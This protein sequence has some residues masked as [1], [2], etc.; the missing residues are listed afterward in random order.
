MTD[1]DI[2]LPTIDPV[3]VLEDRHAFVSGQ[4]RDAQGRA[5]SS[6]GPASYG[7]FIR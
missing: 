2:A 4:L 6:A 1:K 5:H 3:R 7:C